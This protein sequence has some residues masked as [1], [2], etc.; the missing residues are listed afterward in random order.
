[1]FINSFI[2][3]IEEQWANELENVH[4]PIITVFFSF[5][6]T[7][8]DEIICLYSVA[9]K[10]FKKYNEPYAVQRYIFYYALAHNI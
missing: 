10:E 9:Y 8:G 3:W 5:F 6:I 4:V 2:K 1:M 7:E